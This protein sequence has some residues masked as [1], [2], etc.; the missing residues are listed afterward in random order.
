MVKGKIGK[1]NRCR[2]PHQEAGR[3][4]RGRKSNE[5]VLQDIAQVYESGNLA[6]IKTKIHGWEIQTN[7]EDEDMEDQISKMDFITDPGSTRGRVSLF[8]QSVKTYWKM[9]CLLAK[10]LACKEE[11]SIN[12]SI[13]FE[14]QQMKLEMHAMFK[15]QI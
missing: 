6:Q 2:Q 3:S 9:K 13:L 11:K 10:A 5:Q 15:A 4:R 8:Q 14:L 1:V 12:S 7:N